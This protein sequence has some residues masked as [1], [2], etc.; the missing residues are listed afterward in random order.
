MTEVRG[1]ARPGLLIGAVVTAV[2]V[3]AVVVGLNRNYGSSEPVVTLGNGSV[4]DPRVGVT[5]YK[6]GDRKPLPQLSGPSVDDA[7]L[8][9]AQFAGQ[10]QV[11][12]VW[13]SWCVPCREE[14]PDLA[15]VSAATASAGVQFL[16]IDTRDNVGA[17][18]A[19]QRK[20]DITYP[21]FD[22]NNSDVLLELAGVVPVS[23][24]PSTVVVDANGDIAA[25]VIG[26]VDAKTLRAMIDDVLAE[27]ASGSDSGTGR[28]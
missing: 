25:R 6:L 17:A 1:A 28:S 10:V 4:S 23:A 26:K 27:A 11:I 18:I 24:V 3:I 15:E 9:T 14:A 19:F 22:D 13:G 16:G 5:L 21:S 12:N 8:S 20:F 7:P 2:I